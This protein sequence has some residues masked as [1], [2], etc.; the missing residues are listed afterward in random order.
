[1]LEEV[2]AKERGH[3]L[4]WAN[5]SHLYNSL[6]SQWL[7]LPPSHLPAPFV[8]PF[9]SSVS[10]PVPAI[11]DPGEN[12]HHTCMTDYSCHSDKMLHRS[13]LGEASLSQGFRGN[14]SAWWERH[15]GWGQRHSQWPQ[16]QVVP[17]NILVDQETDSLGGTCLW[18]LMSTK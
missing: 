16:H 5:G 9:R 4:S 3:W 14:S 11:V 7:L 13:N 17:P 15:G 2:V 12:P 8:F 6:C 18:W 10:Q 1:M